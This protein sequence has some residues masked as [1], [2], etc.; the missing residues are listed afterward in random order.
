MTTL[1][2][3]SS[4]RSRH[5]KEEWRQLVNE[6]HGSVFPTGFQTQRIRQSSR[7]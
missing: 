5:S 1:L 2:I 4:T 6:F 7:E 3:G